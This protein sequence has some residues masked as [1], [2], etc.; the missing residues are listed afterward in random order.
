[1]CSRPVKG[2]NE[3]KH[4][5]AKVILMVWPPFEGERCGDKK[6]KEQSRT[7]NLAKESTLSL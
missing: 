3:M 7:E 6:A 5:L 4:I 2:F 1:M